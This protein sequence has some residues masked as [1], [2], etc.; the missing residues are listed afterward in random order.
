MNA[1]PAP[2]MRL[3]SQ[4]FYDAF[5]ASPIG[6]AIENLE[7][8]PLFVNTAL[9]SMLGFS[10][11]ELCGK[12]CM[13]FS[14]PEDAEKDWALFEEL[15]AGAR[16]HYQ[17]EKR[18][19]RRDG[20]LIWG[21]L[22]L[23][24]L[25]YTPPMVI[26]MVEDITEKKAAEEDRLRHTVLVESSEDAIISKDLNGIIVSWNAAAERIFGY[27]EAE[28]VGQPITILFP[29]E[30]LHEESRIGE[31]LKTGE[32]IE[33]YETIRV[34]KAGKRLNVSLSI[35]PIKD[36]TGRLVGFSKISRD[37]TER[38]QIEQAFADVSRKL[39]KIQEQERTRIARDLHD[40]I[41][42]RLAMVAIE[43]DQLRQNLPDSAAELGQ[44]LDEIREQITGV[45]IGVQSLS[46]QL[47]SPQLE[48][49][50]IV[51]AIRSF[52]REFAKRR[53]VEIDFAHGNDI[54]QHVSQEVSLCL[55]RIVQEGLN[56]AA[57]HSTAQRFEVRLDRLVNELYLTVC[58][59]GAGFDP[60]AASNKEGLG[61]ISMRERVRLVGGT[62]VIESR[63][64]GGTCIAV[65]VPIPS[66]SGAQRAAG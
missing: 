5:K 7:G 37:I 3:D 39:V 38:K 26:A 36:A 49:L 6:I 55:F 47:H 13:E 57:R 25:N 64:M 50:G 66:A 12:H 54:P 22:S 24:L 51:A 1:K 40:D 48:Y 59:H 35:S 30:L 10:E 34:N 8:Q 9:C 23:S 56:N 42:Q 44:R 46:H 16:D 15:R 19:Y 53:Q 2:A 31:R 27:T 18:Y 43:V 52:C 21:R 65:R 63:P 17:I 62:I 33:H 11:N 60:A 32:R 4:L 29:P 58:D 41:N 61:L 14:P 45:S 20:S 28:A